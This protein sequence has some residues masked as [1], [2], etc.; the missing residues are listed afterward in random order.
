MVRQE[1]YLVVT[2]ILLPCFLMGC[3]GQTDTERTLASLKRLSPSAQL[4]EMHFFGDY[5]FDEYL[6][7]GEKDAMEISL[8]GLDFACSCFAAFGSEQERFFGR[9]FD[10][11]DHTALVLFTDPPHGYASISMVD[12]AYLGY[13][14]ERLPSDD[15]EDLLKAPY[16]PFDGMNEKGLAVSMMAIPHAEGGTD[17]NKITLDDLELIRLLLDKAGNVSEALELVDDY[18]IDFGNVPIHYLIAD[19][20]G[21]SALVEFLDGKPVVMKGDRP[22]QVATNF[23]VAE[24]QPEGANSSCP[25]YNKLYSNLEE[26]NGKIDSQQ[27]MAMLKEVAQQ[28]DFATRWSWVYDLAQGKAYLAFGRNY[29]QVYEFS[30]GK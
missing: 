16:L 25:R 23:L 13:D 6:K 11:H 14:E 4:Y 5:G 1:L 28:G 19:V 30:L 22:W 2:I 9:N 21:N 8:P 12:I 24:E 18:N 3:S 20:S 15:P 27:G 10:W 29:E 17:P 26:K 7:T